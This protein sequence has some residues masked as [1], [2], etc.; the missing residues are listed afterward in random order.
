MIKRHDFNSDWW[1]EETG[2][3]TNNEFFNQSPQAITH[4]LN[5]YA[6]VEYKNAQPLSPTELCK[7]GFFHAGTQLNFRIN[8]KN[9]EE[10]PSL[11][12][13]EAHTASESPFSIDT[14]ALADFQHERFY[15]LNGI[16][17]QKIRE[18][19]ALWSK[20][21]I[22]SDP[23]HCL[24]I[25]AEGKIQG[26]FLAGKDD[27]GFRLTLAMNSKDATISGMLLY[28]KA[29]ATFAKMGHRIGYASFSAHNYPVLNIYATLGARFIHSSDDWLWVR[30]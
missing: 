4:A 17:D 25:I 9:I 27:K 16:T 15:L 24:Q 21:L 29:L 1:G 7:H 18:R 23:T 30:N 10:T 22:D 11:K 12:S 6:W 19:Y 8:L 3:V 2:I 20:T 26:W 28:H 13:I 5:N 14:D